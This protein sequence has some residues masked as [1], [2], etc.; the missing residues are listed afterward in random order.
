[1]NL[2]ASTWLGALVLLLCCAAARAQSEPAPATAPADPASPAAEEATSAANANVELARTHFR[3]GIDSYRDGDLATALIEFKRAYAAAPSFRLLFNLGQVAAELRDYP[4]AER[5]FAQYL[6]ESRGKLDDAR[7]KTVEAELAKVR[8]RIANLRVQSDLDGAELLIDDVLV[9]KTPFSEPLRIG[10]GSRRI[11]ARASGHAPIT[12]IIDAASGETVE[13]QLRFQAL[14]ELQRALAPQR[15]SVPEA[16][17]PNRTLLIALGAGAGALAVAGG[18]FAY[19]AADDAAD[20]RD[21]LKRKTST[22]ELASLKDGAKAKALVT[23]V[24]L[25]AA[26]VTAAVG[27]V[28]LLGGSVSE[29]RDSAR[30]SV[31]PGSV[32]VSGS[33]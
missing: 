21:A 6:E 9:G 19:L 13:V 20:Y 1:M 26:L 30:L 33:F 12:Q 24:L 2:R 3:L 25:G 14:P 8:V 29:R 4:A 7:Q 15:A 5:Y 18:I 32:A 22:R 28:V 16:S 17:G 31:G 11:T 23:D 27:G 10:T